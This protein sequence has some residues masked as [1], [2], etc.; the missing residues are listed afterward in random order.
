MPSPA[1]LLGLRKINILRFERSVA[2]SYFAMQ[3]FSGSVKKPS[4]FFPLKKTN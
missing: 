1:D 3:T 2:F 4:A